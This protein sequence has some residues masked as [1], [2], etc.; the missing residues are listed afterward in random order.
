MKDLKFIFPLLIATTLVMSFSSCKKDEKK[1]D[2]SNTSEEVPTNEST[3]KKFTALVNGFAFTADTTLIS[4]SFDTNSNLHVFSAPDSNG[5]VMKISLAS[6]AL[7]VYPVNFDFTIVSYQNGTILFDGA[8]NPQGQVV[9]T[10][11]QNN[12]ITGTFSATLFNFDTATSM[13]VM[14]GVF[15]NIPYPN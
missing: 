15:N 1:N 4:Y 7:N 9:I 14:N 10:S 5:N 13:S 12:K 6:L 3:H 8:N 2:P 11:N